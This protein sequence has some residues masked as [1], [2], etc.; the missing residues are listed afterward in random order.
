MG[1]L[2][3]GASGALSKRATALGR[4]KLA[5]RWS[6]IRC[7]GKSSMAEWQ[8]SQAE[9]VAEWCS[10]CTPQPA[11]QPSLAH[12]SKAVASG[13]RSTW[14]RPAG[15]SCAGLRALA[16]CP[17]CEGGRAWRVAEVAPGACT[18]VSGAPAGGSGCKIPAAMAVPARPRRTST[19][20][21]TKRRLRRIAPMIRRH[22]GRLQ[23]LLPAEPPVWHQTLGCRAATRNFPKISPCAGGLSLGR[24]G[25]P[26]RI[27]GVSLRRPCRAF[28]AGRHL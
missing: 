13:A 14:R 22:A 6:G 10:S 24:R 19:T 26:S 28:F 25:A 21:N 1:G 2:S 27:S 16:G 20:I 9:Q 7:A 17:S 4:R 12:E 23:R 18:T 15:C 3:A 11:W 8:I 5:G